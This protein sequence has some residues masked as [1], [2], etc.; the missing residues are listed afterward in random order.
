MSKFDDWYETYERDGGELLLFNSL[1]ME[2]AF[3]AGTKVKTLHC[4]DCG[5]SR[6]DDGFHATCPFCKI[7]YLQDALQQCVEWANAYP[8]D[9]FPQPTPEQVDAVCKKLGFRIDSISAMVLRNYT[10]RIGEIA[11][12]ALSR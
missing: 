1:D 10:G 7:T 2:A 3:R 4:D 6:F 11:S 5:A 8:V 12:E 9:I